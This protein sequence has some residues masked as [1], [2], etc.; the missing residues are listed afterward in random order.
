M[1]SGDSLVALGPLSNR[2]P[3]SDFAT[4]DVRGEFLVL[5]FDD[6]VDEQAQFQ[7]IVPSH[8]SGGQIQLVLVWT[9]T[10]ATTGNCR[11]RAELARITSG[12][13]LDA[14]PAV[15][16]AGETTVIAPATS[17]DLVRST[18]GPISM[19]GLFAGDML[20]VYV[21][22]LATDFADTLAGDV[23]LVAVELREA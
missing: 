23:E 20:A 1:A 19:P 4:M 5:D 17:G 13:N 10:S 8:F 18:L 9:S 14:S 21:T 22:R 16:G 2:P 6:A 15:G 3:D 7:A 11:F 12:S